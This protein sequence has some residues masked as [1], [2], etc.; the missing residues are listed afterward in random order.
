MIKRLIIKKHVKT[1][2]S[3]GNV[4]LLLL[5]LTLNFSLGK[6]YHSYDFALVLEF[7]GHICLDDLG[8]GVQ[9]LFDIHILIVNQF[10]FLSFC[11][12]PWTHPKLSLLRKWCLT[13]SAT[14]H[15]SSLHNSLF[16]PSM[17]HVSLSVLSSY[18]IMFMYWCSPDVPLQGSWVTTLQRRR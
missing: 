12:I 10:I 15:S 4:S 16:Q 5:T 13:H 18:F 2:N 6:G 8:N 17:S 11:C 9:G 3:L 1:C 14:I 7:V